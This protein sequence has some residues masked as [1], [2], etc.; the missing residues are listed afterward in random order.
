MENQVFENDYVSLQFHNGI[1]YAKYKVSIID[2]PTAKI[3]T[4]FRREVTGGK[5][6]PA[7]A[8]I[9][10]VKHVDKSTRTFFAS[11]EAGEDLTALAVI[12]S[13]PVTRMM[14]NFFLKFHQPEYPFRFFT[15]LEQAMAWIEEVAD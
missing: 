11:V 6:I 14:G 5:K 7:V 9:S 12:L 3:A 8:D 4:A 10:R 1:L 15:N 2:L 13:N